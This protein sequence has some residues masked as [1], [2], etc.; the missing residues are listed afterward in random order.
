[1]LGVKSLGFGI[2]DLRLRV[3]GLGFGINDL[4]LRV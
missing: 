1:M 3:W 4:G 2:N